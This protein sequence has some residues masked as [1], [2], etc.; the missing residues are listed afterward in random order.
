MK[1]MKQDIKTE[2]K[3]ISRVKDYSAKIPD[4]TSEEGLSVDLEGSAEIL[5][6]LSKLEKQT[7]D[8]LAFIKRL[9][10]NIKDRP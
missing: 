10:E 3:V 5:S 6:F 1:D 9:K 4:K 2:Q 7:Q 8:N